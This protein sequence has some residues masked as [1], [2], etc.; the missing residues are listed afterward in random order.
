MSSLPHCTQ[1]HPNIHLDSSGTISARGT[2]STRGSLGKGKQDTMKAAP[3]WLPSCSPIPAS[4]APGLCPSI[5]LPKLPSAFLPLHRFLVSV[6]SPPTVTTS[7]R[8]QA[9]GPS[10]PSRHPPLQDTRTGPGWPGTPL[11]GK[12][13]PPRLPLLTSRPGSPAGPVRP[14]GPTGPGGPRSPD[15]PGAPC[16]PGSPWRDSDRDDEC[17]LKEP[18][19]RTC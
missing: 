10:R 11:P 12:G 3:A 14:G 8:N 17:A 9:L 16:L 19:P 2:I 18:R 4:G 6:P 15:A 5:Q 7:H 1:R 13:H